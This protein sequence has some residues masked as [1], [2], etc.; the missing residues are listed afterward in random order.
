M[1]R[2]EWLRLHGA[3]LRRHYRGLSAFSRRRSG[4]FLGRLADVGEGQLCLHREAGGGWSEPRFA[5][6]R[7][8]AKRLQK[9]GAGALVVGRKVAHQSVQLVRSTSTKSTSSSSSSSGAAVRLCCC[10]AGCNKYAPQKTPGLPAT[11]LQKVPTHKN[12]SS[13]TNFFSS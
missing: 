3:P 10:W 4:R 12:K 9:V 6:V 7:S 13:N 5:P 8:S 11:E 2:K 1:A